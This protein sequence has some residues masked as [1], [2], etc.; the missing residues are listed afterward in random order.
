MQYAGSESRP[1]MRQIAVDS[2][3]RGEISAEAPE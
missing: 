3:P 1:K 2:A